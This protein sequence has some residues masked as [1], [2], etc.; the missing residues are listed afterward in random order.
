MP[1]PP[2]FDE[3]ST[4]CVSC[5]LCCSGALFDRAR[6]QPDELERIAGFGL[7]IF[8]DSKADR[9][10]LP[11]ALL[12]GNAC[13]I[14]EQRFSVCR[15]F[16][17]KT[18]KAVKEGSLEPAAALGIVA[19]AKELIGRLAEADSEWAQAS[20]RHREFRRGPPT[21]DPVRGKRFIEMLALDRFL[22]RHFRNKPVDRG[23]EEL[24][25]D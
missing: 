9:F 1:H 10:R 6:A 22:D 21:G 7:T 18:L 15:T 23:F 16:E 24:E 12:E 11:C 5:G 4:L 13:T 20:V 25:R 2:T 8:A 17:C 3:A 19:K 14:Y